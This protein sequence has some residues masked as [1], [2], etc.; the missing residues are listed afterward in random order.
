M[1]LAE[2]LVG[3]SAARADRPGGDILAGTPVITD[4][5]TGVRLRRNVR[6]YFQGNRFL[7]EPLV[8]HVASLVPEGLFAKAAA[9]KGFPFPDLCERVLDGAHLAQPARRKPR[10]EAMAQGSY[11]ASNGAAPVAIMKS[12]G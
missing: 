1:S 6:A 9:A 2:G 7:L 12:V 10:V 4:T 5:V 11:R 8:R 3:L